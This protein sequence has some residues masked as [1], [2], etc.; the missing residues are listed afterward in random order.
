GKSAR[1]SN[2]LLGIVLL[3]S[4]AFH[5]AALKG[6]PWLHLGAGIFVLDTVVPYLWMFLTGVLIQRNWSILRR[7][8]VDR[9]HWWLIG[10]AAVCA[11]GVCLHRGV[12]SAD[13]GAAF[14]L[15]LSGLVISAAM[16][17]RTLS[18]RLLQRNDVSYGVYI[19]HMLGVYLIT[20]LTVMAA[21]IAVTVLVL[22]TLAVAMLSWR[23]V[24]RPF[25]AQ[26][27]RSLRAAAAQR[28]GSAQS[29]LG[30]TP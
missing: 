30:V 25:L 1:Q 14:F 28:A 16:S 27:H 24:E 5:F 3:S 13:I 21:P 17:Y 29:M 26:K 4:L 8:F 23:L 19:Y 18:E 10:Y 11:L 9:L 6:K 7:W 20:R 15:P 2:V 12:G 22:A